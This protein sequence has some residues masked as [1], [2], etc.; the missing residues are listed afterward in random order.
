MKYLW[1][2]LYHIF[3]DNIWR[4]LGDFIMG[5]LPYCYGI[6]WQKNLH[7]LAHFLALKVPC[8][9]NIMLELRKCV[10]FSFLPC[11]VLKKIPLILLLRYK[12]MKFTF[13][14]TMWHWYRLYEA[15]RSVCHHSPYFLLLMLL[16]CYL[17]YE[18][19]HSV[20]IDKIFDVY[21]VNAKHS[22]T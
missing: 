15:E 3:F 8:M 14:P 9:L 19:W 1:T 10:L 22:C 16:L 17:L 12:C 13:D 2:L 4:V 18:T 21:E 6:L 7:R 20:S 5:S 11:S